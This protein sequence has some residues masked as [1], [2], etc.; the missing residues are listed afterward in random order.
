M[1]PSSSH[2]SSPTLLIRLLRARRPPTWLVVLCLVLSSC[3]SRSRTPPVDACSPAVFDDLLHKYVAGGKV[4]YA[5][6]KNSK[7]DL[8]AFDD[9]LRRIGTCDVSKLPGLALA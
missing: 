3:S 1:K 7:A 9:Y 4:D 5:S 6:L 2:E 8:D